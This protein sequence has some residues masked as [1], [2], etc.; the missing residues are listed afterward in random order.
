MYQVAFV[1]S[2]NFFLPTFLPNLFVLIQQYHSYLWGLVHFLL[3]ELVIW[4]GRISLPLFRVVEK[5]CTQF[6]NPDTEKERYRN[7]ITEIK[8]RIIAFI[9]YINLQLFDIMIRFYRQVIHFSFYWLFFVNDISSQI[10]ISYTF[11]VQ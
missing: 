8:E 5:M 3:Q 2:Y 1:R 6:H 11:L 4:S 10:L 9:L 7:K